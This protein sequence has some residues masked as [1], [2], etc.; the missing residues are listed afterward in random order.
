MKTDLEIARQFKKHKAISQRGLSRQYQNTRE[1]QAFY[2]GDMM[3]YKDTVQFSDTSGTRR[4][5]MVQFNLVKPYVDAVKGFMAQNRRK[6][7]YVARIMGD[8]EQ[9]AYTQYVNAFSDFIRDQANAD[10]VETQ[11][12]GDTL[13]CGY[14]AIETAM[15]YG[16]GYATTDPNG[17]VVMCALDNERVGWDP[18]SRASNLL[19]NRW[20]YYQ[21]DYDIDEATELFEDAETSDF[22]NANED[23]AAPDAGYEWYARGGRYNKIKESNVD[24]ADEKARMVKVY[25]YQWFEYETFYRAENPAKNMKTTQAT[26][27]AQQLLDQLAIDLSD[28]ADDDLFKFDPR[29][30]ILTFN[31]K[32]KKQLLERFGE[33]L[34]AFPYKRK[35]YYTA[36]ISGK[37]VFTKYRNVCQQGF[38]VKFTTGTYDAK[39]KIWVGMVNSMKQP[40]LYKNKALTELMFIIGANSKGGVMYEAGSIEDVQ[41]FETKYAKTDSVIE[42][43]EGA[44]SEGRI[45]DKRAPFA[46]TGYESVIE[47]AGAALGDV[48]G[49]DKTF[50]GSSENKMETAALQK[51]RIRQ[52]MSGL[53]GFFDNLTL[54]AK[55]Q[56]RM[57]LDYMRVY[58]ENNDGGLFRLVGKDGRNRFL[59][60]SS[61]KLA[62]EYDVAIQ[63]APE[64]PE[65]KQEYAVI[66][67]SIGD[68]VAVFNQSAALACYGISIKYLPL[69]EQD[70]LQLMQALQPQQQKPIDPQY[71]QQLEAQVKALMGQVTQSEVDERKSKSALN[72]AK[73]KETGSIIKRNESDAFRATQDGLSKHIENH[74]TGRHALSVISAL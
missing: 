64:S 47:I 51:R 61:D 71:V 53:A 65:D 43:A 62:A 11:R 24:W 60:I 10:Q 16:D 39:N 67:S 1:C 26:L 40:V 12:D 41:D 57:M 30:D 42:V 54:Y 37:H 68:K 44:L 21:K 73:V 50:L 31:E 66:I 13:I 46:P 38:T 18:Y 9:E 25:F 70:K 14:A 48:T 58:A 22:E 56:G 2:A 3:N 5:A 45:K 19:D 17:Q 59:Q 28:D 36:V 15:T 35:V 7:K 29:A 34:E 33:Y 32:Y 69:E 27:L 52:V 74:V 55:D 23:D 8:Q 4:R 63:E 72:L 6:P 20:L 49:L